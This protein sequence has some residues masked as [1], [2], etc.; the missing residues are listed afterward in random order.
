MS[1]EL[2]YNFVLDFVKNNY[3]TLFVSLPLSFLLYL[4]FSRYKH[5]LHVNLG[6]HNWLIQ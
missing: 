1:V 5:K 6:D 3:I 4:L 2:I